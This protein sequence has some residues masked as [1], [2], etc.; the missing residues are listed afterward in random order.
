MVEAEKQ[1]RTVRARVIDKLAAYKTNPSDQA[2][3]A[4]IAAIEAWLA[5]AE[6]PSAKTESR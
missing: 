4:L 5:T 1:L 6:T 3:T 2:L